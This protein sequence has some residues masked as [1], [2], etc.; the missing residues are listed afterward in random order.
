MCAGWLAASA[1]AADA[2][3]IVSGDCGNV[4]AY[5]SCQ[6]ALSSYGGDRRA[7]FRLVNGSG[8]SHTAKLFDVRRTGTYQDVY[9]PC[10]NLGSSLRAT[11]INNSASPHH[12]HI[13]QV[14]GC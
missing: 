13:F 9:S 8:V 10:V 5:G 11:G 7:M 12:Y 2:S 3:V 1:S 14:T 4:A 6:S